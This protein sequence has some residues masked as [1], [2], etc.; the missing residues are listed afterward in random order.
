MA[1]DTLAILRAREER[2]QR[3][4]ELAKS[5]TKP[6]IV[7]TI[8]MPGP[9]KNNQLAEFLYHELIVQLDEMIELWQELYREQR[10]DASGQTIFIVVTK[11]DAFRLKRDLI[12]I[13]ECHPLGR[14]FDLDVYMPN[15]QAVGRN[16]I[17]LPP[18][19][20]LVCGSDN[21]HVC[22]M[23]KAHELEEVLQIIESL[24]TAYKRGRS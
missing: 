8:N 19:K 20:C 14:L 3:V 18:R 6:V 2:W 12:Q 1:S 21:A 24:I 4:I 5:K 16:M 11:E 13:E 9:E 7:G 17:G 15:G 23:S 22:R 10:K